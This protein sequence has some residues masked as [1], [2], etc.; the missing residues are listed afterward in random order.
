LKENKIPV[1]KAGIGRINKSD[2]AY[3]KANL[4][5]NELDAIVVGFNIDLD[6]EAEEMKRNIKILTNDVIYRLVED[7]LEFREGKKRE[8]E[9]KRMIGLTSIGK[10]RVLHKYV[11]RNTSPAIFGIRIETGKIVPGFNLIDQKGEKV[12]RIKNLQAENKSVEEATESQELAISVPGINFERRMKNVDFM[13]SDI[14]ESQFKNFKKNKDLLSQKE[15]SLLQEI[16]EIK[17]QKKADWGN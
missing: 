13:Y 5:I 7:I 9:K 16:A 1:V 8:I 17:R 2:I 6:E 12:G 15:I 10:I 14:T 11:F 4:E 3:A